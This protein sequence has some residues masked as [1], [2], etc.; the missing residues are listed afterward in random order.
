MKNLLRFCVLVAF[1]AMI[2]IATT[3]CKKDTCYECDSA[4]DVSTICEGD[5]DGSGGTVTEA[6]LEAAVALIEGFG[7]TCTKK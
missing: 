4:G 5:D 7:G 2:S 6:Q 1:A 3:S